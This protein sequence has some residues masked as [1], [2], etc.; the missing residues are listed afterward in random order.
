MWTIV[1][2]SSR[3]T[4]TYLV[5]LLQPYLYSDEGGVGFGDKTYTVAA[6]GLRG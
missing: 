4:T 6:S 3:A 1:L 2:N 5:V